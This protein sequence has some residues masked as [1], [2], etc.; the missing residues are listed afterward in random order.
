[1]LASSGA[2][3]S[4]WSSQTHIPCF[5]ATQVLQDVA[6]DFVEN[7]AAFACELATHRAGT[8]LEARDVQLALGA[9]APQHVVWR[10]Q[11]LTSGVSCLRRE[12]LG[13]A[14]CR[15]GRQSCRPEG[16][17]EDLCHRG[18]QGQTRRCATKQAQQQVAVPRSTTPPAAAGRCA[19]PLRSD[20]LHAARDNGVA[21]VCEP[22]SM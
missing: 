1:M 20:C 7:L 3:R 10:R 17:Q 4:T 18:A 22:A 2:P 12:K 9:N 21:T 6:D 8:T 14:A 5:A 11:C 16:H 15:C 13:H 19:V